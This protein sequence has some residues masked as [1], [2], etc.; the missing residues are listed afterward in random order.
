MKWNTW[1]RKLLEIWR[2]L[3]CTTLC[4]KSSKTWNSWEI[5]NCN[6][7]LVSHMNQTHKKLI[8]KVL[9]KVHQRN[10]KEKLTRSFFKKVPWDHLQIA[11]TLYQASLQGNYN[12]EFSFFNEE[13]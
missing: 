12:L 13:L 10:K 1:K 11:K 9:A 7:S 4:N 5:P 8:W 6:N 3:M 2:K